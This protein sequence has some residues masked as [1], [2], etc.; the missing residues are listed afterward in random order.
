MI[1]WLNRAVQPRKQTLSK[2]IYSNPF[3]KVHYRNITG[4][5]WAYLSRSIIVMFMFPRA[6]PLLR[7]HWQRC[8]SRF[9]P[10]AGTTHSEPKPFLRWPGWQWHAACSKLRIMRVCRKKKRL[11]VRIWS[12][13]YANYIYAYIYIIL[14]IYIYIYLFIFICVY[15]YL[16]IC[17]FIYLSIIYLSIYI[18]L[19]LFISIYIYLYL[20]ISIYIYLN[21]FISIYIY[22]YLF[23]SIYIY[24][25]LFISI[26]IYLY[27]FISIYIY[28]YLFISIYLSI[29]LSIYPSIHLSIYPSIYLSIYLFIYLYY[30]YSSIYLLKRFSRYR[31]NCSEA[32]H[33]FFRRSP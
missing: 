29:H 31:I 12:D 18:Y 30:L 2:F 13:K 25:Y 27:L 5:C 6:K 23:I 17:C 33:W 3:Q 22:L 10:P 16:F 7:D 20:F 4:I 24:L 19:Y 14:S 1:I 11:D 15:M 8:I 32:F 9:W 21:L 28:L 26:Y